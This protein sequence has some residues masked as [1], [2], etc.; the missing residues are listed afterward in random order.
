L[1]LLSQDLPKCGGWFQSLANTLENALAGII[2]VT[3]ENRS[4]PWLLFEAGSLIRCDYTVALF[5]AERTP[6][7]QQ[8][9]S[10]AAQCLVSTSRGSLQVG[11]IVR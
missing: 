5:P 7:G 1:V 2:C 11:T 6:S 3:P 9:A 10:G 4:S 8:P